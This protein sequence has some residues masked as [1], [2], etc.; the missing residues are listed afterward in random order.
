MRNDEY[1]SKPTYSI[2]Q[3]KATERDV[4]V[5]FDGE[6]YSAYFV[7]S[8]GFKHLSDFFDSAATNKKDMEM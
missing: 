3:L 5:K 1:D 7:D 4:I 6:Q 2:Y 8:F